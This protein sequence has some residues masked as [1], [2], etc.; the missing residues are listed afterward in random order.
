M[1]ERLFKSK[2]STAIAVGV[3]ASCLALVYFE[4]ATFDQIVYGAPVILYFLF[5]KDVTKPNNSDDYIAPK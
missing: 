5:K 4:K 1:Y 3:L 2:K